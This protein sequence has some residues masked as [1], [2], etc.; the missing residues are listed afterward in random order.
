MNCIRKDLQK[1]RRLSLPQPFNDPPFF[2]IF[3][4][5]VKLSG[6]IADYG[7]GVLGGGV[8]G[9]GVVFGSGSISVETVKE[10]LSDRLTGTI[11][12]LYDRL[13]ESF[14]SVKETLADSIPTH[15]PM[16]IA[17][18]SARQATHVTSEL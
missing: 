1:N 3:I 18:S 9:G 8:G 17:H 10:S 6:C 14:Q 12:S 11:S 13:T 16:P 2:Q 15:T 5:V 7:A 4:L